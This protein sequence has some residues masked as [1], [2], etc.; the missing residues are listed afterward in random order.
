[1]RLIRAM[2]LGLLGLAGLAACRAQAVPTPSRWSQPAADLSTQIAD[3]L[4]PGQAQVTIRNLST[5]PPSEI[6]SVRKL[7][8]Q[9]LK[10]HGVLASGAESANSIRITLS[11]NARERIWVAEVVEGSE[12]HVA[13]VHV[14]V[15]MASVSTADARMV[16]RSERIAG[17][18]IRIGGL[19][20]NDPILAAA[21]INGHFLVIYPDRISI[22]SSAA[23][24]WTEANTI[25]MERQLSRDP[26]TVLAANADG[27]LFTAYMPGTQCIGN[28][29]LPMAGPSADSGWSVR[30]HASDDPWPVYQSGD[31]S[32]ATPL[33]AFY[34][35]ARDFFTGIVTPGIG[36]D[37]PP[38][39]MAVMIPRAAGGAAL[40]ISSI[41][42]NVQLIENGAMRSVAGT[43][44]WGSDFAVVRSGCGAG[45]Q[46]IASSSGEAEN[47]SLRAFEIPALEAL[48]ASG[49][50]TLDGTVTALWTAQ[51]GKSAFAVVRSATAEYEVDRV[52]ALCN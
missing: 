33:K 2:A 50:L 7:I 17:L 39:Y 32:S 38:F 51:D 18:S 12:T 14:D 21:E 47:D 10:A 1:M 44:D 48:P 6:P 36:V 35:S 43:R 4:G 42:G 15:S 30:C 5:I 11:E 3:I 9:D 20:R 49:P 26:R 25:M 31:A 27:G 8:E 28:Y 52:T 45:T 23:G 41:D 13:M 16:L 29:S 22:F 37:L 24:V 40:L 19:V 46:I 34:N